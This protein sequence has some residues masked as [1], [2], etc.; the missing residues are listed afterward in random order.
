MTGLIQRWS[1]L[2]LAPKLATAMAL[3]LMPALVVGGLLVH[4]L[5]RE[6]AFST[7]ERTG[8]RYVEDVWGVMAA[9]AADTDHEI[10]AE[11][12]AAAARVEAHTELAQALGVERSARRLLAMTTAAEQPEEML[13]PA[14]RLI[15]AA[16]DGSNLILDPELPTYYAMDLLIVRLPELAV[17]VSGVEVVARDVLAARGRYRPNS[18]Y[19]AANGRL[20]LAF[21]QVEASLDSLIVNADDPRIEYQLE[22]KVRGVRLHLAEVH[23]LV[24]AIAER[25][26]GADLRNTARRL[27]E[28]E[29]NLQRS[30]DDM[31]RMTAPLLDQMLAER[32]AEKRAMLVYNVGGSAFLVLLAA[33]AAWGIAGASAGAM[34]RQIE[35]IQRIAVDG[36][37]ATPT[38]DQHL[39]NDF[40]RLARSVEVFRQATIQR[41]RL[42]ADLEAERDSLERRVAERT[43]ELAETTRA[44]EELALIAQ[45]ATDPMLILG[46]DGRMEWVNKPHEDLTGYSFGEMIGRRPG[47]LFH[48][49]DTDKAVLAQI[50]EALADRRAINCEVLQY[51]K[52]GRP[53]VIDLSLSPVRDAHGEVTKF[54]AVGRD[55][56][57]RKELERSLDQ[58]RLQAENLALIARH[59]A[60][61]MVITDPEGRVEW[62]NAPF[63]AL[64]GYERD[65]LIGRKPGELLQGPETD[66]ETKR[67]VRRALDAREPIKCEIINYSKDGR[68]YWLDLSISPVFDES[69]ALA[70]FIAVE[71]DITARK[72]LERSLEYARRQAEE[73]NAA[74]SAFL[75]NMSHELRTPLNAVIGYAEILAEDLQDDGLDAS[76]SD[77]ER[78]R[79]AARHLLSLINEILDLSKIEAGR[80]DIHVS[81]VD[82]R[83]TVLE[84]VETVAPA[85]QANNV[86]IDCTIDPAVGLLR[87]DG[88]KLRQ[89]LLNL[90]S[91][92]VKFTRD[93]KVSVRTAR[94]GGRLRVI[95][96]DTGIGMSAEQVARLFQPFV[97]AD[98]T[99]S[100]QFGGTGLGLVITR[101]LAQMIG[102]DVSVTSVV[103]RGSKFELSI[104][105][106]MGE[107]LGE[108]L[109]D[110]APAEGP[111]VLVVDDGA[112]A[113]DLVARATA[114]LG[115]SVCG[116]ATG[117]DGLAIV[118]SRKPALIILDI[119]L[120]DGSGWSI[121]SSLKAD[122][123]TADVPVLVYSIDDDRRTSIQLGAC[124]HLT[125]PVDRATLAAV[126]ARFA[127]GG[128]ALPALP[129][130]TEQRTA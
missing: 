8:V 17:A 7:K 119:G 43:R 122:P 129:A 80:M 5:Q 103:G 29:L 55:V 66:P 85:A 57:A 16:G 111:F 93:G 86:A 71:R 63:I 37:V 121:L 117:Q 127:A 15:R 58:A 99:T 101:R 87:T 41:N 21:H 124:E 32:I 59:G 120:P 84:A 100:R 78:I 105:A 11:L 51:H 34:R 109:S 40:G 12:F 74:K 88:V 60:D 27:L 108:G 26:S 9:A 95:V 3:A 125:K 62:V 82:A 35:A 118:R 75:A 130:R 110:R 38:P 36:D 79:H 81:D 69:G 115:L 56:T 47:D 77:A 116:A 14:Q 1:N 49:P 76:A 45:N 123:T 61:P 48:G 22:A 104:A 50:G 10:G 28:A 52:S 13:D 83:A 96:E 128:E 107:T 97:Q 92:A 18:T 23:R 19:H 65:E 24:A 102:G 20:Q 70:R 67:M 113:R 73:A 89:C 91:N 90:L 30:I 53:Y 39:R 72:D 98:A 25:S 44:A 94:E 114:P 42:A 4:T 106:R 31:W 126:I 112:D 2:D 33:L 6:I 68:A 54:I 64:T 46:I